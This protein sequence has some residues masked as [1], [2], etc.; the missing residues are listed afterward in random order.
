MKL[1]VLEWMDVMSLDTALIYSEDLDNIK[2]AK[3]KICVFLFREDKNYYWLAKEIWET[4]Q[5]K[6]IH[7]IP[8][9]YVISKKEFEVIKCGN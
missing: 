1:L 9:K 8:K 6:Y 3:C 2:P 4:G 7:V 5:G